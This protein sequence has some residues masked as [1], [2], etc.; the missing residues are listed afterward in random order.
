MNKVQQTKHNEPSINNLMR[1]QAA[2]FFVEVTGSGERIYH[3]IDTRVDMLSSTKLWE[4]LRISEIPGCDL[5][6]AFINAIT[7]ELI[8][9]TDYFDGRPQL[10]RH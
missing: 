2:N 5:E 9:R 3:W 10:P 7:D 6:A 4:I 8:R 1:E